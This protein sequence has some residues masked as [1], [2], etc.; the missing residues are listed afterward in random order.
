MSL[1]ALNAFQKTLESPKYFS[2]AKREPKLLFKNY[3][4]IPVYS[5][6]VGKRDYKAVRGFRINSTN[7][8]KWHQSA[9]TLVGFEKSNEIQKLYK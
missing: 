4:R 7:R 8:K 2:K 9:D 6:P 5:P 1:N 3:K